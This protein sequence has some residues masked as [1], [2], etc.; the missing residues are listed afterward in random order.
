MHLRWI[1]CINLSYVCDFV[2]VPLNKLI[3]LFNKVWGFL[4][5]GALYFKMLNV[6]A[7]CFAELVIT[8]IDI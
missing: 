2:C 8:N 5:K 7:D 1:E 6:K 3:R 4:K